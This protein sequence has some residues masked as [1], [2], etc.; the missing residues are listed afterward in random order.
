MMTALRSLVR[1]PAVAISVIAL[2]VG[3]QYKKAIGG[4]FYST[5]FELLFSASKNLL[6]AREN[7]LFNLFVQGVWQVAGMNAEWYH[8]GILVFH[9]IN[10]ALLYVFVQHVTQKK[11][12][13]LIASIIFALFPSHTQALVW[14]SQSHIVL[15][16]TGLLLALVGLVLKKDNEGQRKK[17]W[18]VVSV[19]GFALAVSGSMSVIFALAMVILVDVIYASGEQ[20]K[21]ISLVKAR[22]PLHLLYTCVAFAAW[23]WKNGVPTVAEITNRTQTQVNAIGKL[24]TTIKNALFQPSVIEVDNI[25]LV[26]LLAISLI[27]ILALLTRNE[28]H[29]ASSKKI[30]IFSIAWIVLGATLT[31]FQVATKDV[32]EFSGAYL[33]VIAVGVGMLGGFVCASWSFSF[34]PGE[35][36]KWVIVGALVVVM[37]MAGR[38][39]I[40]PWTEASIT[41]RMLPQK[42]AEYASPLS[43]S[44]AIY[45]V[46]TPID[47][48]GVP[49]FQD[50]LAEAV[51]LALEQRGQS[52]TLIRSSEDEHSEQK[53]L[54]RVKQIDGFGNEATPLKA[55]ARE[56]KEDAYSVLVLTWSPYANTVYEALDLSNVLDNK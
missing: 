55:F 52:V 41:T 48:A 32:L 4:F 30:I 38:N 43:E 13:A 37:I 10:V 19:I 1:S 46:N 12:L 14:L 49:A 39:N 35:W 16:T 34:I 7:P 51:A 6:N 18:L 29:R 9:I 17:L 3:L 21:W 5:D 31:S 11:S 47:V 20:K 45:L 33:Y 8:L 22:L 27:A 36:L 44:T 24:P 42:V 15:Q 54:L 56:I 23:I 25:T 53:P 28:L 26:L 40:K 2:L 50:G